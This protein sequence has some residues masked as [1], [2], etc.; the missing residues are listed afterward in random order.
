MTLPRIRPMTPADVDPA[1]EL[2]LQAD[3]G[4]RRTWFEFTTSHAACRSIVAVDDGEVVGT[5]VGTANGHV[6]WVGTIFVADARRGR[7]LGRALTEAVMVGLEEVGCSTLLLVS[8]RL[9]RPLYERLGFE[10]QTWYVT[11]EAAGTDV[12]AEPAVRTFD[13]DDLDAMSALD[14]LATGEDRRHLL[15]RFA[16]PTTAR[17]L[18]LSDGAPDAFVIRAPWGGGATIA[19]SSDSAVRLLQARRASVDAAHRVRAG[20]PAQNAAGIARL[21]RLG[22]TH[23]YEAPR[24]VRGKALDWMPEAIWGQFNMAL[25]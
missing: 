25:G 1:T 24:M 20:I 17:V 23:A 11:M 9:G 18:T 2:I 10:L 6:G 21:E 15:E 13:A 8:T 12:P 5:G 19:S 3:W 7:G 14:R 4:D 16:S 22:W